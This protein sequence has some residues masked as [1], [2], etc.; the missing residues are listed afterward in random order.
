MLQLDTSLAGPHQGS[1]LAVGDGELIPSLRD[2]PVKEHV[3]AEHNFLD[4]VSS[5]AHVPP[6][7]DR[8]FTILNLNQSESQINLTHGP[9]P[10]QMIVRIENNQAT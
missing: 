1:H 2:R 3:R 6:F 8:V 7:Y 4:G 5:L 10:L 9:A